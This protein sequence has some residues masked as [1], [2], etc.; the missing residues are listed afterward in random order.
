MPNA[1][2]WSLRARPKSRVL[3]STRDRQRATSEVDSPVGGEPLRTAAS[4]L[5]AAAGAPRADRGQIDSGTR[6]FGPYHRGDR[7][8]GI[9]AGTQLV[10][11]VDDVCLAGERELGACQPE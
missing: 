10:A 4:V 8:G 5:S 11:V 2:G 6:A 1:T 7:R 3:L 9:P